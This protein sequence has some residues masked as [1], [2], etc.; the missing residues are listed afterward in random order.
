MHAYHPNFMFSDNEVTGEYNLLND[1][2]STSLLEEGGGMF[3]TEDYHGHYN[4]PSYM[5]SMAVSFGPN[6][7]EFLPQQQ[8]QQQQNLNVSANQSQAIKGQPSHGHP[9]PNQS[10]KKHVRSTI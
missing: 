2:L 4:D 3:S 6:N 7:G 8:Q 1:F 9:A 10:R 5:N